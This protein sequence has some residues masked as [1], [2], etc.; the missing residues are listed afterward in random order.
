[1]DNED[2]KAP[3]DDGAAGGGSAES[4]APGAAETVTVCKEEGGKEKGEEKQEEGLPNSLPILPMRDVPLLPGAMAS[5][6]IGR[7]E[8][9]RLVDEAALGSRLIG[10]FAQRSPDVETPDARDLFEVGVVAV[11][12]RML[13]IP[14][15]T[16]RLMV[17][18]LRRTRLVR[19]EAREPY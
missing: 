13:K 5:L 8:S 2:T 4:G 19:M 12:L 15:G 11:I 17:Q 10:V 3:K 1:M 6:A 18:G 16:V 7:K 14:D 9:V